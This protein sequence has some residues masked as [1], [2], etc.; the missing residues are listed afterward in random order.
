ML[1][2]C[3]ARFIRVVYTNPMLCYAYAMLCL[4]YAMLCSS[5]SYYKPYAML[6][7]CYAMLCSSVSY[8]QTL[9]YA[10]A[11]L[12]YVHPCS[13]VFNPMLGL[14]CPC[15][16]QFFEVFL[17]RNGLR[18]SRN[19]ARTVPKRCPDTLE[20]PRNGLRTLERS[21]NGARGHSNG[22]RTASDAA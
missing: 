4:C 21:P 2:L 3:Y 7:L 20:R 17:Y 9:C 11:M 15:V 14:R 5:V 8:I 12:C 1:M 6:C 16:T 19:C 18:T 13:S 22:P 10:Y